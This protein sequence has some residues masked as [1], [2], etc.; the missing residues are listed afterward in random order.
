MGGTFREEIFKVNDHDDRDDTDDDDD[1]DDRGDY[2]D[3]EAHTEKGKC[4]RKE[5]HLSWNTP[6][7]HLS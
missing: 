5:R 7:A 3:G 1:R 4:C 6:Q 2:D